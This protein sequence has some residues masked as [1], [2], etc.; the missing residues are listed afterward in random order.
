[1][2][3]GYRFFKISV[4]SLILS[5][6]ERGVERVAQTVT[7]QV[8][9]KH[10]Q[11]DKDRGEKD[12][13]GVGK[14]VVLTRGEKRTNAGHA[15]GVKVDNSEVAKAGLREDNAGDNKDAAGDK[16]TDSVRENMLEHNSRVLCAESS[17]NQNVFLILEAVEL[18]SCTS[19][20][21]CPTG[22]EEGNKQNQN[23]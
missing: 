1:L 19:C 15:S 8:E 12:H 21:T 10:Q 4:I 3:C 17:R 16:S 7:E 20:H 5:S 9:A 18:H 11:A 13:M 2:S 6:S 14:Q 23:M 22:Q